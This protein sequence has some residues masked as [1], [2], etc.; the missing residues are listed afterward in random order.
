M[1]FFKAERKCF[2]HTPTPLI[3][4]SSSIINENN[5]GTKI[6]QERKTH[7]THS[8]SQ[9]IP[10]LN[11]LLYKGKLKKSQMFW[12]LITGII[13]KVHFRKWFFSCAAWRSEIGL[14]VPIKLWGPLCQKTEDTYCLT[15]CYYKLQITRF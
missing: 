5:Q 15:N 3:Y 12:N 11:L 7:Q 8:Q 14:I 10:Q 2:M 4:Y 9:I 1:L 6:E 13:W